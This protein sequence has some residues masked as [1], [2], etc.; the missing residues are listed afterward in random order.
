[1][2]EG[3]SLF[4]FGIWALLFVVFFTTLKPDTVAVIAGSNKPEIA[5]WEGR[6]RA[7]ADRIAIQT[8]SRRL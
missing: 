4:T 2:K 6:Q 8:L 5:T 1:M 3:L 7:T